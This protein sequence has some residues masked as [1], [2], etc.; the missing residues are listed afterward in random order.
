M[1]KQFTFPTANSEQEIPNISI[2]RMISLFECFTPDK[3]L[4][5]FLFIIINLT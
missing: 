1:Y 4:G 2:I 5:V 3:V